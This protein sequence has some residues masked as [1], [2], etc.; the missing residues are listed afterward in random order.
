ME[1]TVRN[2]P[3]SKRACLEF[4]TPAA[5]ESSLGRWKWDLADFGGN[6]GFRGVARDGGRVV[7]PSENSEDERGKLV[8]FLRTLI[9]YRAQRKTVT[10]EEVNAATPGIGQWGP[11]TSHVC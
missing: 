3:R 6:R 9:V 4:G 10:N 11:A 8:D 7:G 5:Y 2:G 1:V